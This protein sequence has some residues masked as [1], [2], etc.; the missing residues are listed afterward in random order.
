[1]KPTYDSVMLHIANY[2]SSDLNICYHRGTSDDKL[3]K[4]MSDVEAEAE[5]A[6]DELGKLHLKQDLDGDDL[7]VI[8]LIMEL[9]E[10]YN[11]EIDDGWVGSHG[12]DPSIDALARY[13][14]TGQ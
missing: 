5:G 1:M 9:E 8:E 12:D 7:D 6:M 4:L 3:L 2:I 10:Y 13:V 11:I 14:S